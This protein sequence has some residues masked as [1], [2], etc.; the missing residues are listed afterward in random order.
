MSIFRRQPRQPR[1][2]RYGPKTL[3]MRPTNGHWNQSSVNVQPLGR[4]GP[5]VHMEIGTISDA[6]GCDL[7]EDEVRRLAQALLEAINQSKDLSA[8]ESG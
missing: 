6:H 2:P 7:N 8:G 5:G 1:P 3:D 4:Y